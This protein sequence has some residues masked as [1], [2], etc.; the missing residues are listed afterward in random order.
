VA[1]SDGTHSNFDIDA[2]IAAF[3]TAVEN[4]RW[5]PFVDRFADDAVLEFVGPPVGP[6]VGRAAIADAYATSPPDDT[7]EVAGPP[8]LVG[9]EVV[10]PYRWRRTGSTGSMRF[11]SHGEAIDR[12]VVTFD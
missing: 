1:N 8:V 12:L 11:T 9:S 5:Q 6:F 3:N 7:I 4:G 2:H 10:V